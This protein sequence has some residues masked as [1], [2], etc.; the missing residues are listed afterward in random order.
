MAEEEGV[1]PS[2]VF[3]T[4][5][6]ADRDTSKLALR[7]LAQMDVDALDM[8]LAELLGSTSD[9]AEWVML[10]FLASR[11]ARAGSACCVGRTHAGS[12]LYWKTQS[13]ADTGGQPVRGFA[14]F[15]VWLMIGAVPVLGARK[16]NLVVIMCDD[17]GYADVGFN[18][19]KDIPTPNIDRIAESGVVCTS[20]YVLYSVCGSS[21]AGFMTGR[22]FGQ[23]DG[24]SDGIMTREELEAGK[25]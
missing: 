11:D 2:S 1:P 5:E 13:E 15:C 22:C 24:N 20:G 8:K 23:L 16:P 12:D 10:D 25:K 7:T 21:R 18:G 6:K 3:Q 9:A 19:C 14:F 4:L 17:L